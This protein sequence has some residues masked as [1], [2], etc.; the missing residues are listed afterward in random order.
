MKMATVLL[1]KSVSIDISYELLK[2]GKFED[3]METPEVDEIL[4]RNYELWKP[5]F[6]S[7]S[8]TINEV[9]KHVTY[10][11]SS[12]YTRDINGITLLELENSKEY[13]SVLHSFLEEKYFWRRWFVVVIPDWNNNGNKFDINT[14][15]GHEDLHWKGRHFFVKSIEFEDS[16]LQRMRVEAALKNL[17]SNELSLFGAF[18]AKAT[19]LNEGMNANCN[20]FDMFGSIRDDD[21]VAIYG[22]HL[23]TV[24]YVRETLFMSKYISFIMF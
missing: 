14:C 18:R 17:Q 15:Y 12:Q 6:S 3:G 1:F 20:K 9:D 7:L 16:S 10:A 8:A 11:W 22:N 23:S 19:I 2:D 4:M 24:S 5:R 13:A 21:D